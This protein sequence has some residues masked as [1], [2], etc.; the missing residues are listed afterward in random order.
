MVLLTGGAA[1]G[2]EVAPEDFHVWLAG[3]RQEAQA[4]GMSE[5]TLNAALEGLRPVE[6]VV[7]LDRRQPE[8]VDTFLN[9]LGQRVNDQR[10]AQGRARLR[11]HHELLRK[12]QAEYGVPPQYLLAFWGME[13]NFGATLGSFPVI[14]VL[15]TLAYDNRRG[16]FF[17]NE[18][19]E[20]LAII[21]A[22]HV[23][24]DQMVGSWAGAMGQMQF[25]PSTFNHYAV[26][27]DGDGRID[28]WGSLPDALASAA[29][30]L[31]Q[32]GWKVSETWGRE[33]RLPDNF[34]WSQARLGN[35]KTVNAWSDLGVTRADGYP[36]PNSTQEGAIVLPQG[37]RGPA[38]LVYNNFERIFT[39]NRS[40][41]YALAVGHLADRLVGGTRLNQAKG[42]DNRRLSRAQALEIQDLLINQ[43]LYEGSRDGILGSRTRAAIQAYQQQTGLP[44]DGYPSVALL[45]HMHANVHG[46]VL[47]A[48]V[49][50][51]NPTTPDHARSM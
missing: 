48:T 14:H 49:P 12:V 43:G 20:A 8:F 13:T 45:E 21:D 38:F 4:R 41:N 51:P 17:R 24:V 29:N 47:K 7:Q 40:L 15:A 23:G 32:L 25:M 31:N 42:V 37:Y 34:D 9:Y 30:Y 39:W 22:G 3:V 46:R 18:L 27:A 26:D 35:R 50:A 5:T 28:L 6:R 44:E 10:V 33:V 19:L 36:L 2:D 16:G 11:A 1:W